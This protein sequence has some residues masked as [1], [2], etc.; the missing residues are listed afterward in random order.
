LWY[1]HS[2]GNKVHLSREIKFILIRA[3]IDIPNICTSKK[4]PKFDKDN[5][6]KDWW[7]YGS[8]LTIEKCLIRIWLGFL[9][10]GFHIKVYCLMIHHTLV[11]VDNLE[12]NYE[13]QYEPSILYHFSQPTN[14]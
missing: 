7:K 10:K 2:N 5:Y 3:Q 9:K 13:I 11:I 8:I 6:V 14:P 12:W 1:H 4:N